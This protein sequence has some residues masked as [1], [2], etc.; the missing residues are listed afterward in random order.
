[1][2]F[3][4]HL[5]P[6]FVFGYCFLEQINHKHMN[7]IPGILAKGWFVYFYIDAAYTAEFSVQEKSTSAI[8]L[9]LKDGDPYLLKP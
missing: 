8:C 9:C 3:R 1:M 6:S 5:K 7:S 2:S 4:V